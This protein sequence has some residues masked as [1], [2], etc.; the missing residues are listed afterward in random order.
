MIY[1]R[2][3]EQIRS[4]PNECLADIEAYIGYLL[5]RYKKNMSETN[6]N[7][8][9]KYFGSIKINKDGLEIQKEMR[10]EWD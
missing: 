7:D 5:Y 3:F 4:V 6:Q 9:S 10:H 8:L 2:L 1:D